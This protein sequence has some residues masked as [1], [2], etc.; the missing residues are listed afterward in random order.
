MLGLYEDI[1]V[2]DL[3]PAFLAGRIERCLRIISIILRTFYSKVNAFQS[4]S[5]FF[6]LKERMAFPRMG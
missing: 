2:V 4:H 1:E 6:L 3:L 5:P